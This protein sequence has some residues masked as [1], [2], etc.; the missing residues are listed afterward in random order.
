MI[1][2]KP[3]VA[4]DGGVDWKGLRTLFR[5]MEMFYSLIEVVIMLVHKVVRTQRIIHLQGVISPVLLQRPREPSSSI[6]PGSRSSSIARGS[7]SSSIAHGSRSSSIA[8]GSRSSSIARGSRSS[9]IA[10]GSRSSSIRPREP[11]SSIAHGSR[12]SSI[13]HGSPPP[14]SPTGVGPPPS[15]H[16]SPPPPSPAGVGPPP[17]PAGALLL[18]RPR[19]SVLLHRPRE[20]SSSIAHGSRSSSI[21]HGSPPPPSPT[22][23]GP[24]P[25]PAGVG[26]PPSPTGALLLH[27]PRESVLL[28]R[29]R[30]PVLLHRARRRHR[31]AAQRAGSGC[32]GPEP[33]SAGRPGGTRTLPLSHRADPGFCFKRKKLLERKAKG[34]SEQKFAG[35][36]HSHGEGSREPQAHR[37][38][39]APRDP[40]PGPHARDFPGGSGE[41]PRGGAGPEDSRTARQVPA[42]PAPAGGRG[43]ASGR[44]SALAVVPGP[45]PAEEAPLGSAAR[46]CS[47]R[48]GRGPQPTRRRLRPSGPRPALAQRPP[49]PARPASGPTL[50]LSRQEREPPAD[51]RG[52][53]RRLHAGRWTTFPTR[54]RGRGVG[55]ECA[56]ASPEAQAPGTAARRPWASGLPSE[57][58]TARLPSSGDPYPA[59]RESVDAHRERREGADS[60][61]EASPCS[62]EIKEGRR[63]PLR[64][65]QK[66][67]RR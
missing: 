25:S 31:A 54:L 44:P 9:S 55:S 43:T 60:L 32:A 52:P 17:S 3:V 24:P 30:E 50:T 33:A 65:C 26:P 34:S 61:G 12:S 38:G 6:P 23:V 46:G 15:A 66:E 29:P 49:S 59:L 5:V 58:R 48:R 1:E 16:G 39:A 63:S 21:A 13:A 19:E 62:S 7:R 67:Q 35:P 51:R 53:A 18:H 57:K 14:P 40:A 45:A 27:R 56:G 42:P 2:I 11:S 28:H 10:H 22:G 8:R 20:P 41:S 64:S 4:W 47:A 36:A 37:A